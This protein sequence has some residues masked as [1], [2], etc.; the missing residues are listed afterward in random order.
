MLEWFLSV[1]QGR[2]LNCTFKVEQDR[3]PSFPSQFTLHRYSWG[4]STLCNN[5]YK[6]LFN[7]RIHVVVAAAVSSKSSSSSSSISL[8]VWRQSIRVVP[9]L[10]LSPSRSPKF[11]GKGIVLLT[12]HTATVWVWY[13]ELHLEATLNM[14]SSCCVIIFV[15]MPFLGFKRTFSLHVLV[16]RTDQFKIQL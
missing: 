12:S 15:F 6:A 9:G 7:K 16:R 11:K 10:R 13:L 2:F 3:L 5:V 14:A 1:H 4:Y 8:A